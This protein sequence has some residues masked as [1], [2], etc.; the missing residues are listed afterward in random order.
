MELLQG[1]DIASL[2]AQA[3]SNS[4]QSSKLENSKLTAANDKVET[5]KLK[6]ET[7]NNSGSKAVSDSLKTQVSSTKSNVANDKTEASNYK[8]ETKDNSVQNLTTPNS[9]QATSN[10]QQTTNSQQLTTSAPQQSK[11]IVTNIGTLKT[12]DY[13]FVTLDKSAYT[14][15]SPIPVDVKGPKGIYFMVQ[16]GAFK[17][18]IPQDIF[19]GITPVTGEKTP[20]G[21]IRYS[22]GMFKTFESCN[23]AKNI[24]RGMGYGDAFVV[25]YV[26]GKR[27]SLQD[28][29][30]ILAKLEGQEQISFK[31]S[32]QLELNQLK[33]LKLPITTASE[34]EIKN[35]IS[36][37]NDISKELGLVYTVQIGVY[38]NPVTPDK[39][40]NITPI[41]YIKTS[42]GYIRYSTGQYKKFADADSRKTG[43]VKTGIS[44]AFVTAYFNGD[45]ITI[46]DAAQIES[47]AK[48]SVQSSKLESSKSSTDNTQTTSTTSTTTQNQ[49]SSTQNSQPTTN[50]QQLTTHNQIVFKVQMGAFKGDVAVQM[51]N[52]FLQFNSYGISQTKNDNGYT[53][54]TAGSFNN[55]NDANA[56]KNKVVN[57]GISDAFVIALNNGKRITVTEA[58][59]LLKK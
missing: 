5:S 46:A 33:E 51:V 18:A 27:V 20:Q 29:L 2:L 21:V 35:S 41:S 53:I 8:L 10:K 52:L 49:Q 44:D 50:S 6:P 47:G 14:Q 25:A 42:S 7:N 39:L 26:D 40:Y 58:V 59:S 3:D 28:A 55:I 4:V 9:Q 54:Y 22:A 17:N 38:S 24:I 45:R 16:V 34:Q 30:A 31:Q 32:E 19:K 48:T 15:S 56:L 13:A 37:A 43:V 12:P 23:Y 11:N 1:K 57:A 36:N